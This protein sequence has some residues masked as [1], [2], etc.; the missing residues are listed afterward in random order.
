MAETKKPR[1]KSAAKVTSLEPKNDL[2]ELAAAPA[3]KAVETAMDVKPALQTRASEL[4]PVAADTL[5]SSARKQSDTFRQAVGEAVAVSAK[6]ALEVNDK[7]IDALNVQSNA[8]LDLWR[9]AISPAPLPE[10]FKT[11]SHAT[12]QAYEAASAQWKD[13]AESTALWF[14][15]SLEPLQSAL[16]QQG[17]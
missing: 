11:Q 16:H 9:S 14:T 12:R 1:V 7:I 17:R 4:K 5:F 8:A 13:I 6:G 10:A 2:I 15:K 3:I